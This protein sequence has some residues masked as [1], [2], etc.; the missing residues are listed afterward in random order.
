VATITGDLLVQRT[1]GPAAETTEV[2][3]AAT[4]V[5]VTIGNDPGIRARLRDG[6]LVIVLGSTQGE[7]AIQAG[8]IAE[9]LGIQGVT[10][11]G[12][13]GFSR[14]TGTE[15]V[16]RE[17]VVSGTTRAIDVEGAASTSTPRQ[18]FG[19]DGVALELLG[20]R[21]LG[22]ISVVVAADELTVTIADTDVRLL[23]GVVTAHVP[24]ATATIGF[25]PKSVALTAADA[26][27]AVNLPGVSVAGT[28]SIGVAYT[29]DDGNA[30]ND[31]VT[32][33]T[34]SAFALTIAGQTLTGN[35]VFEAAGDDLRVTT[36]GFTAGL[37]SPVSVTATT[38]ELVVGP[39]GVAGSIDATIDADV[40]TLDFGAGIDATVQ[41]NTRLQPVLGLPAGP[42]VRVEVV[43]DAAHAVSFRNSDDTE[44]VG[45]LTGTFLFEQSSVEGVDR[46]VLAMT[47]V[48]IFVGDVDATT[49]SANLQNGEGVLLLSAGGVAGYLS[50][51]VEID[52]DGVKTGG[53]GLLRINTT[54]AAVNATVVVGGRTISIAFADAEGDVFNLSFSNAAIQIG[55]D[56]A[57]EGT[58]GPATAKTING[59][60]A[61]VRVGSNIKIFFGDGPPT[62]ADGTANPL[63]R[64]ILLTNGSV[65]LVRFVTADVYAIEAAG[66]LQ[67]VGLP[68]AS[69]AGHV[70][71]RANGSTE[72][73]TVNADLDGDSVD[74]VDMAFTGDQ[75]TVGG[76][77]YVSVT[78]SGV[79]LHVAGQLLTATVDVTR[80]DAGILISVTSLGFEL[81]DADPAT[82]ARGPPL[83]RLTNGK[84][85]LRVSSAGAAGA[86][87]GT[88]TIIVPGVTPTS[89]TFQLLLNTTAT[90]AG[91]LRTDPA[92]TGS[93]VPVPGG[94]Y[95]RLKAA[96]ASLSFAGQS[97]SGTFSFEQ[98]PSGAGVVTTLEVSSLQVSVGDG[99]TFLSLNSG[100]GVLTVSPDGVAGRLEATVST[101]LSEFGI[102][103]GVK[104]A[105]AV[106]TTSAPAGDLPAGPTSASTP[107]R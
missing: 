57:I 43:L 50:G 46:T 25:D 11:A 71:V 68:S 85:Q 22:D 33:T 97:V 59:L 78:G 26:A 55:G 89:A 95:F 70:Q 66:D 51:T 52:T 74:D 5:T 53:T 31:E 94:P 9:V 60:A 24:T 86:F 90:G 40:P 27:V 88:V 100:S 7:Y 96:S 42:F 48:E 75:K 72:T 10:L 98:R 14:N 105:V 58:F 8:G 102:S 34:G 39:S 82:G 36:T 103:A 41:V 49:A 107:P 28:V 38:G 63:A 47:G 37:G 6:S 92:D 62:L 1:P 13:V 61:E 93:A 19:G 18:R 4:D 54:G 80:S 30:T 64:G 12:P 79:E 3:L 17:V 91:T 81:R 73:F 44:T 29:P 87:G 20:Q 101:G 67:L 16:T 65:E 2:L 15:R 45:K 104:L 83:V 21:L 32:L 69:A 35:F 77:A 106:N 76:V 56:V 84:G 99:T 23:D